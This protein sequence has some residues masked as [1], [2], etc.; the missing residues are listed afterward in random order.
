MKKYLFMIYL[1]LY[2]LGLSWFF[3][4]ELD[5]LLRFIENN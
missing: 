5:E 4:E 2:Q 1:D 3:V